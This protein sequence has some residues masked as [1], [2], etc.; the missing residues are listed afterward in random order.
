MTILTEKELAEIEKRQERLLDDLRGIDEGDIQFAGQI[1]RLILTVRALRE[2]LEKT[3]ELEK[4]VARFY[5]I[6]YHSKGVY[7]FD[8]DDEVVG[9]DKLKLAEPARDAIEALDGGKGKA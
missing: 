5:D 6:V 7:G 8:G 2:G 9:W 1:H 4:I 3:R